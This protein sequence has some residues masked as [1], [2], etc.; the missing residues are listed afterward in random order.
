VRFLVVAI[1][2]AVGALPEMP[3]DVLTWQ[4]APAFN[5]AH[6][7]LIRLGPETEQVWSCVIWA[8]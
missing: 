8:T 5:Q 3:V 7:Y 2:V 6:K 1:V 4:H